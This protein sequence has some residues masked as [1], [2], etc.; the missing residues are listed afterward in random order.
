[1]RYKILEITEWCEDHHMEAGD[2]CHMSEG[3]VM[4]HKL[5][6]YEKKIE[7]NEWPGLPFVCEAESK[8][9]AIEKYNAKYC[10]YDY[11]KAVDAEFEDRHDFE[12]ILLR[13]LLGH[14]DDDTL[15][16]I[17]K[18][19]KGE[20]ICVMNADF[21]DDDDKACKLLDPLL[22]REVHSFDVGQTPSNGDPDSVVPTIWVRLKP[23]KS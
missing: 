16:C 8:E 7:N 6:E 21:T 4:R 11:Y 15:F 9:E 10:D 18:G 20:N 2:A 17:D 14:A 23:E 13:Q 3:D 12:P 19:D 22:D 5:D 1:M